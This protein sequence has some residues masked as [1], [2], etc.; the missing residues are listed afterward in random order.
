MKIRYGHVS[1]SSSSSFVLYK[2]KLT[3]EQI[4]GFRKIMAQHN[5]SSC[6]GGLWE[7]RDKPFFLGSANN[8][9]YIEN[10]LVSLNIPDDAWCCEC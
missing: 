2:D 5:S 10:H 3:T 6:E 9:F 7:S 8:H 1:N 4:E